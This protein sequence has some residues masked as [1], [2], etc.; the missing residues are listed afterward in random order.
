M[1]V[2]D[3]RVEL[4][5]GGVWTPT[6]DDLLHN[7][8]IRYTWGRRGEGSRTDPSSAAFSLL[9]PDGKYS[10]RNP[11]S[12]YYGQLGRNTG[13]RLSHD[14]AGV[15]LVTTAGRASTPDDASLDVTGD[16][17]LRIDLTPY[18]WIGGNAFG[19][20]EL[21]AKYGVAG[22]RSWLWTVT[23]QGYFQFFWT[24]DGT[25]L[26]GGTYLPTIPLHLPPGS[27]A[28]LRV[29]L[30]V[31]NG[32]GGYTVTHY[33]ASTIAGPW[34][35]IQQTVTTS[36]T[37]SIFS[38]AAGVEVG[39]VATV[40]FSDVA[41]Q[42][43]AFEMR[44]GIGGGLVASPDFTQQP[45]NTTSFTD[46]S[47]R[48]WT[49]GGGAEITSRR[50]RAV[51][52]A[53]EWTPRWGAS[54]RDVKT[55]VQAAGVLR[56]LGQGTKP[57][58]ST[59]RRR[60]PAYG[61][62]AYWPM[63][64]GRDATQASSPIAGCDPLFT[65]G[66]EWAAD[67]TCPGSSPLPRI[68]AGALA[69]G[70]VPA[71]TGTGQWLI[72]F[73][74]LQP[75]FPATDS[76][77]LDFDTSG[78]AAR[79]SITVGPTLIKLRGY[80]AAGALVLTHDSGN[81]GWA[82]SEWRRFDITATD[83]GGG[84]AEFHLGWVTVGGGGFQSNA[85]IAASVGTVTNIRTGY[86]ADVADM[87]IGHLV[88]FPTS[89]T[90]VFSSADSGYAREMAGLRAM[91]LA[92]EEG[93]PLTML[94]AAY[95]TTRMGPQRPD[96]L[97]DLLDE[98]EAAEGGI[99]A[100]DRTRLGVTFRARS[101]LYSQPPK[102]TVS[103][104]QL[105]PPLEPT[106]D[107]R[108]L[109]NDRSVTREGGSSARAV[110]A[111]GP[112]STAAVGVYDDSTTLSLGAD[113]QLPQIAAW[114]LHLGT[115]DESRYPR[116]TIYLHKHP[117]L[118][119]GVS[120]LLP[121]DVIRITD[122]PRWLPPGPLDLIVEGAEETFKTFEWTITLACSPAGPWK[123]AL[124]DDLVYARAGTL[125]STLASGITATATTLSVATAAG[126]LWTTTDE[127]VDIVIGGEVMTATT[128]TGASSPQTFTVVR[129]VNGVTKPHLASAPVDLA[130]PAR[131]AL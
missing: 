124:A 96:T 100:E 98:C 20:F 89:S 103:Y 16:L 41:R 63:E 123:T 118:I 13:V 84:N 65:P 94:G 104:G 43:H 33:R 80:S 77:V 15:A 47:G 5:I 90:D 76:M 106:D 58:A 60:L 81:L 61:P 44:N 25:N 4:Q 66:L 42:F 69:V 79:I 11:L 129:S 34:T 62:V 23:D 9:N 57:L 52:E 59:L 8:G 38:S 70:S 112:L 30:D 131:A 110:L 87:R 51:L 78:T 74:Y 107:D 21:A 105:A 85:T 121:G 12:P 26:L 72:S 39:N 40:G 126:P 37:T 92:S 101:T 3:A 55:P 45:S 91:R 29:T 99:L 127:P 28:A 73:V 2:P 75:T 86:G 97:L 10:G 53:S 68:T 31:N 17:D 108:W 50:I 116:V 130:L 88:V 6:A 56:R 128:I 95:Q 71:Y 109:R 119:P 24:V 102:L 32:A 93:L 64:E 117:S 46:S 113:T 14:G 111:S 67:D 18:A 120:A 114:L 49:T 115:W 122:L 83:L 27:R 35:Q 125:G 48:T 36:G 19:A 1:P 22:A 54:G 7:D 82:G